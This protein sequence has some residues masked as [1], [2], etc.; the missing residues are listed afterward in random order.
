MKQ[1]ARTAVY[2]SGIDDEIKRQ[3]QQGNDGDENRN[4]PEKLPIHPWILP[5]KPRS[6]LHIDHAINVLVR[7]LL[8]TIDAYSKYP[9]IHATQ[10]TS[11][12]STTDI[13]EVEFTH[14][15]YP[16][17][18]ATDNAAA[19][20]SKEFQKR[21]TSRGIAQLTA[22]PYHPAANGAAE[23]TVQTFKKALQKSP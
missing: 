19:F 17:A 21:C 23:S 5:A 22:A 8:T 16:H 13:P 4:L 15:G 11:S 6:R 9:S 14:F 10:A 2:W 20:L 3:C 18:I 12:K 7:N 1:L